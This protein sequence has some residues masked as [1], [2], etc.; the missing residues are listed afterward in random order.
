MEA[1]DWEESKAREE[2]EDDDDPTSV[3]DGGEAEEAGDRGSDKEG[4]R[5][6]LEQ[7]VAMREPR[8]ACGEWG[9]Y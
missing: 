1:G 4:A 9:R 7:N 5:D 2:H 3:G 8:V 6:S